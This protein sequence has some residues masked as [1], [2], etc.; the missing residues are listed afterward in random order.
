MDEHNQT[1]SKE[2]GIEQLNGFTPFNKYP[3]IKTIYP[4]LLLY[5]SYN[6]L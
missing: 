6:N 5:Q 1:Q 2:E 4:L 3:K